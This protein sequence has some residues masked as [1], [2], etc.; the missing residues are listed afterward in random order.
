MYVFNCSCTL[1]FCIPLSSMSN[2]SFAAR[3][4]L[5]TS[6]MCILPAGKQRKSESMS[7]KSYKGSTRSYINDQLHYR[8]KIPFTYQVTSIPQFTR[9]STQQASHRSIQ[10]YILVD[11]TTIHF[12]LY[13][14]YYRKPTGRGYNI[15]KHNLQI[16]CRKHS[17]GRQYGGHTNKHIDIYNK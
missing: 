6:L 15:S 13:M 7:E 2:S 4:F 1:M 11:Q 3:K 9:P 5:V 16:T 8:L 14:P 12:K 10:L 17:S